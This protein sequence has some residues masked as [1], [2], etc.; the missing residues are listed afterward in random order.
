MGAKK[1]DLQHLA[2]FSPRRTTIGEDGDSEVLWDHANEE[3]KPF[4]PLGV[5][6]DKG[7]LVDDGLYNVTI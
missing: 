2:Y 6:H 1:V 5:T 3:Q 7:D 4:L